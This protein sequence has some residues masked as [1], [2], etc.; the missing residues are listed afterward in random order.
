[1]HRPGHEVNL[2][3]R[4][5]NRDRWRPRRRSTSALRTALA[6]LIGNVLEWFDFAVYG[7]FAS[8]I[9]KQFFPQS[10]PAAQQLLA[11]AV[12]AL[13]FLARPV[14]SIVLGMV[15]DRI[16]RRALLTLSIALMG[17]ATLA[18]GLLPTYEQIGVAAPLLLVTMRLIQ[19][20]SLGG[21]F[22][23]SMVYTTEKS[24][25]LMRGL[26]SSSTAAG[27]TIG[28]ILGSASAWLVNRGCPRTRY[29][30]GAGASR[31][32]AASC[33]AS[34]A[35]SCGAASPRRPRA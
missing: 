33:S 20:F 21:E 30:P 26:V 35:G 17:G 32:S 19:G 12:F 22:T 11:F 14:G 34:P 2:N 16:G 24:S 29:R 7:Y 6:G 13:G 27:T 4:R 25:P 8:D 5:P 15:G 1:M 31:S 18:L 28:F 23:G 9:G 10:D 3:G